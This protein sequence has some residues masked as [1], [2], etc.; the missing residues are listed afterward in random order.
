MKNL[1]KNFNIFG[2]LG[3]LLAI[4][5]V[6]TQSAF[7]PVKGDK[8]LMIYGYNESNPS[9]PWVPEGTAGYKCQPGNK[10]CRYEFETAPSNAPN[11]ITSRQEGTPVSNDDT[12]LGSYELE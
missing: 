8:V 7:K 9:A 6:I 10:I 1:F 5:L 4:G 2:L 11:N 3:I 12:N